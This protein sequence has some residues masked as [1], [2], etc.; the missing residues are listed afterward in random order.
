[1][2]WKHPVDKKL[3]WTG[4]ALLTLTASVMQ[5]QLYHWLAAVTIVLVAVMTCWILLALCVPYFPK[6][7]PVYWGGSLFMLA[8][9]LLGGAHV[10]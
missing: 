10:V 2:F 3:A 8:T 6:V 1:M 4:F 7:K 5:S 9:S